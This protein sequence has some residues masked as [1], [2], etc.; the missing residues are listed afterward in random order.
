MIVSDRQTS[1]DSPN[2]F[3]TRDKISMATGEEGVSRAVGPGENG[4]RQLLPVTV[5]RGRLIFMSR[6]FVESP[7]IAY[8]LGGESFVRL[9]TTLAAEKGLGIA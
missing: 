3:A 2:S 4:L 9:A 5:R 6:L 7:S 1:S 8:D